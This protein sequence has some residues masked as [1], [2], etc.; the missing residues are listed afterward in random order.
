MF[1]FNVD[2]G[3]IEGV[4]LPCKIQNKTFIGSKSMGEGEHLGSA[5]ISHKHRRRLDG[6]GAGGVTVRPKPFEPGGR[7]SPHEVG[8]P[9]RADHR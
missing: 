4:L 7:Q 3:P 5:S 8:L 6:G 1:P 2:I 9:K